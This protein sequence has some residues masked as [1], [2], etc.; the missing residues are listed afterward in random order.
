MNKFTKSK[1]FK[2]EKTPISEDAEEV[3]ARPPPQPRN[4]PPPPP[5]GPT[6]K[7][8]TYTAPNNDPLE[9]NDVLIDGM[10]GLTPIQSYRHQLDYS[11]FLDVVDSTFVQISSTSKGAARTIT[12]NMFRYYC[13]VLFWKRVY[14]VMHTNGEDEDFRHDE[15]DASTHGLTIPKSIQTY[16]AGIGNITDGNG[17]K[18]RLQIQQLP[19][20]GRIPG[21]PDLL[22]GS[23]GPIN[24]HPTY[25]TIPN[26][27]IAYTMMLYEVANQAPNVYPP[28]PPFIYRGDLLPT[29]NVL[30][31]SQISKLKSEQ[32]QTYSNAGITAS[33][34]RQ[35]QPLAPQEEAPLVEDDEEVDPHITDDEDE[36]EDEEDAPIDPNDHDVFQEL[37]TNVKLVAGININVDLLAKIS[38]LL[39]E[40]GY[41]IM[42]D[43]P[44]IE[45]G[46][47]AQSLFCTRIG[48][49]PTALRKRFTNCTAESRST[50]MYSPALSSATIVFHYRFRR[51]HDSGPFTATPNEYMQHL[52]DIFNGADMRNEGWNRT[53]FH[54]AATM[55]PDAILQFCRKYKKKKVVH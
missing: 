31:Y 24:E 25:I 36:N 39:D 16:L 48:D 18:W 8:T 26:P 1:A 21:L 44:L 23:F 41:E 17:M 46:S 53:H 28:L 10:I 32:L 40:C 3:F 35:R 33:F 2:P 12:R 20:R 52:N 30:G 43:M 9:I 5:P 49:G 51:P 38:N 45:T 37:T 7:S 50:H 22:T 4:P 29:E 19:F 6:H 47:V 54:S 27:A 15:L 11:G 42:P 34:P 55:I 13:N 14:F